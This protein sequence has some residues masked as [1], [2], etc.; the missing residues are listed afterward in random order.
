MAGLACGETIPDYVESGDSAGDRRL[1]ADTP[2]PGRAFSQARSGRAGQ[3]KA[4][5]AIFSRLLRGGRM[6]KWKGEAASYAP[7]LAY[8]IA[9][10]P[11]QRTAAVL[12][13]LLMGLAAN[14][15]GAADLYWDADGSGLQLGGTGTWNTAAPP[16]WNTTGNATAGPF[17][18]WNNGTPDNAIFAGT[19]GTVTLGA[20]ITAGSL[21]FN[22]SGYT[23]AGGTL[24]LGGGTPTITATGNATISSIIAGS[25]GLTKAGGGTLSLTGVNTFTGGITV[26]AGGFA[27]NADAALGAAANGIFAA[28][29]TSLTF[30]GSL[31]ASR[32]VTLGAGG[33]VTVTGAGAAA[34]R[35][36]GSGGIVA[37]T[38]TNAANDYTGPTTLRSSSSV[39]FSSI[40]NLGQASALGAPTTAANGTVLIMTGS[41]GDQYGDSASYTGGAASTDRGFE[42]RPGPIS[43]AT[44]TFR[45]SGSGMLTINGGIALTSAGSNS[46]SNSVSFSADSADLQLLGVISS[47][48][49]R[50]VNFTGTSNART[51]TLGDANT[52][53]GTAGIGAVT[54]KAGTM[55]NA[56]VNSSLGAGASISLGNGS[57][58]SYT[59]GAVGLDRTW[60]VSGAATLQSDGTGALTLNGAT[61]LA[62]GSTFT[63]GGSYTGSDNT[64]SGV[65]SGSGGL[66]SIGNATWVLTGANTRTGA[67]TVNGGTLRAG[68]AS[69]FGTIT[70]ITTNGGTLDLN[71]FNMSTT[72]LV[73]TGGAVA[74]GSGNLTLN[75]GTGVTNT[76]GGSITG[77][78]SLT[79]LGAGTLTLTG[80][81]TYTGATTIGGGTLALDFSPAG[82]PTS[83]IISASSPLVMNGGTLTVKGAAGETNLQSFGGLTIT[84]GNNTVSATSGAGGSTTVSLGAIT[85]TGGLAN[86]VLPTAGAIATSNADGALGG[87]ATV[88]GS[89]YA[90]VVGGNIVAFTAADYV[91][92]DNASLW[93]ANQILSDAG[94]AANTPFFNTVGASVQIGG[95]QYTAAANSTV[96]VASGQTLGIDGT[97]IVAP[98]VGAANQTITGGSMTGTLGGGVLG[99]QQNGT[100]TFTIASTIVDNTG[101]VGFSKAGTGKVV[102]SG[103]NTYTGATT[104]SQGTLSINSVANGGLASAIGASTSA[105]SNLMIQGATLEYTGTGASTDRGFTIARA[106]AITSSTIKVTNAAANL[107]FSG[108][109]VSPDGADFIKDGPGTLTLAGS[110]N[111]Y[112]GTTTVNSGTLAVTTLANGGTNSSIG[113]SSNA[114]SNLVLQNGGKLGYIGTIASSDRGFTLGTGGGGIDVAQATTTLTVSGVATGAG[115]LT[116]TGSGTLVLSGTNTYTGGTTVSAGI[117]RAGSAQAFGGDAAGTGAGAMTVAS[118]ATVDL[119]GN[120]VFV[121]GLNG[122]GNVTLGSGTLK[123]NSNGNFTG[124]IGGTGGVSITGGTQTF[125]GCGNTYAGA[126]TLSGNSV[127]NVGCLANGGELSDIGMSGSASTNLVFS[128]GALN[129]TGGTVSTNRGFTL[130][131][132]TGAIGVANAATTL[133]FS[134]QAT[135]LGTLR[136]DGPGTLMLSGTN[137]YSGGTTITGGILRAGSTSAFGTGAMTV[138]SGAT[139]DLAGNNNTVLGLNGG[140]SVTLGSGTL[141][142]SDGFNLTFSGAMSG[143]GGLVK[144]GTRTQTLSGCSSSY[145]GGTTINGGVLAVTCLNNGGI[146][147]SIGDSSAAATNLVLNGGTLQYIGAAGSTDRQFTL[148]AS[149]GTLDA[150]GTGAINFTSTTPVTL[151]GTG[152][153]TLTLAGSNTANNSLSARIDDPSGGVTSLTKSGA[154]T[155]VLN[156]TTSTYTGVTTISGGVLAVSK[157]AN[158]GQ[159]SS[160][161]Q[162]SNLASNLVIGSG[163]TLRY[164]GAG[165]ETDRLFTLQTGISFIESSGTGAIVFKNTGSAAYTGSGNRT[166]ALG[167]TNTGLNTMGGTI[168]DGPGGTTTLAKNDSGTWVLTGNNTFTGNTV[169][170]D[171]NLIIGNGG[172]SGNAGAGNVI[173]ANAT[174]TLSF[175]RSDSFSFT[176]TLSGAGNIA[177]IGTGTTILTSA[178]NAIG[179][180]TRIDAGTLQVNGSLTSSGG[181]TINAGTLQS[182]GG[183][184]SITTPTMTMNS[185]SKLNVGGG[186]VQ[187][188]GG[189]QTLFAGGTGGATINFTGGTLLGNGTLG[190]GGNIVNLAAGSLNTGAAALNLGSGNDTFLLSGL[191]TIAGVGVDGGGGSDTLQVT[192]TL[193]RTLNGAQITGFESLNKQGAAT[194]TLTGDHS[195]SAGT[196]ISA[197]TLQIGNGG[198]AGA[199]AT[200]NVT[201][202]GTLAFNLNNNYT[203]DSA[204][205]GSGVVNKLGTGTTTLTGTNTYIGATNVNAGTLL[206]NGNQSG[207]IGQTTV[208]SGATLGG[209]GTIG[210]SVTVADGGTLAPGGAGNAPGT[211]TIG[212]NLTLNN[213]SAVNVN[214]GQANVPGGPLND[215]INVGGNLTLDGTLNITQTSGGTFGPGVY[216]ILNYGGS[217]TNNGLNV[218]S[219]DYFVQ[220]AVA[221]QVNLV[222]S[223]GLTLSFW[224]GNAGPHSNDAVDGGSGTWRAAGDQNW[225]DATGTFAAP[226]ANAS[227]AIFQ[228]AAGTVTVDNTN[229]QVQA[230]GMQFATGGYL[231]QA[232]DVALVGLQS[233]IRVGDGTAAGAA[234]V[235]TITSNLT[236]SSQLLKTELGT[237]VLSGTNS[238]SG[239]TAINGGTVQ[240]ASDTNLGDASGGLSLNAGTLHTTA[241]ITSARAVTLNVGGGTFDTDSATKLTL[242]NTVS[243]AGTLTKE[244]GGTLVLSGANS[245]QSGT[246]INGGTVQITADANLGDAAG[247]VTFDGGTFYQ[248]GPASI[249]TGRTATLQAGGGTFQIDSTVQ[250]EGAIDGAGALTKTGTGALILGADNSYAGGTTISSGIL[251]LGT[252]GTTGSI[253]GDVV[254]NGT[255]SFN[256][257]DLYTFGGTIS[258]SGGVTQDGTGNTVLTADNTYGGTT[259]IVGGGGLYIDGDQSAA[260]GLANVNNGTLGGNGTIGGDVFVDVAG[261]LAPGGLGSTP[262]TL[263]INGNLE[264]A[265]SSNLD[266]SFGQAGVVGGA[267]NDLTVVHGNLAL[268]GTINVTEAPG[269]NFG[270]GIYRVISYDGALTDNGLD[271]TSSDHLVQTSVAGQV[272]LVDIS[273]MTLN[274]WDGDAGP[275]AN[276][277]VDG[278]NGTWRA[279]G[280]DNWTGSDGD[281]NAAFSNGSFAIFAGSAGTVTVDNTNGQV[282]AAGMQFATD[283]YLV[284][285]QDIELV[286]SQ[287][288]MR[289]GDGTLPGA[290]YTAT[291]NSNLTG[292]SQ[293]VKT[294]LGTLVLGGTN[295]Y[296]GGTAIHSG[297]LQV[298]ADANLGDAAGVLSFDNGATLRNTAAF[299]SARNVTLNA[300]GGTFQ[301]DAD[302]TLSGVVGGTGGFTKRGGA[303]LTLTG[304]SAY[305]GPTTVT[306]GGLYIDGDNSLATGITSVEFG[307]TLGGKGTI[308]GNVMVANGATLSP[309]S[310]DGTPGTLAIAGDLTLSGGSILNYSFGQA[311]VAGGAL[312]DLTTVGGNLVLDG[313][314]NV[315][316]SPGGTFGPG[317]YRVF[318][319]SGTLTNNGL[320]VGSIPSSNYFVQ[321]SVDHQVNLVNAN[322]L[323]LNYWD[324]DA[325]P[326]FDGTINGGNGTWQSS[327]GNDN[328]TED[329]GSINAAYSD[330][331]FAIFAGQAGTV[332]VDNGLGQVTAAG[333][334]FSTDGYV[335]Q[336]G[337][338]GLLGPQSTIRVGDGTNAGAG[339]TATIASAFTGSA[340][341]VK[342]DAGTLVLTGTNSYT[343]GTAING[344]TLRISADAN[345]GDAAGGLS[346][347][348]GTLNSTAS[349][350]SDRAIDVL[351]QGTISTD[352]GTTLT[353]NGALTGSGA[354]N[355]AGD[356]TLVLTSAGSTFS[357]STS[358]QQGTLAAG[359]ADVLSPLSAFTVDSSGTLD[360][361]SFDQTVAS[362]NNSG[363][364][365]LGAA[366]PGTVLTVSGDYVGNGG[367]ILIN[368]ALDGDGSTTDRLVVHGNTAG[369]GILAVT[370]VGGAGAQTS[371]GIKIVDIDGSSAG[372]FMLAGDYVFEGDQAVVGGAYAYRLY[373]NGVSTPADGDWYLRSTLIN[374]TGP[375]YAPSTPLYEAYEGV[376]RSFNEPGTLQQR[377]GNRAWGEGATPQG[378]DVPGQGPVDGNAIWA[379][380]DA[381]HGK[382]E[383]KTSTTGTDYDVTTW[384]LNAGVDG[385][386]H[387]SEAGILLGG[388]TVHYGTVSSDV[389]SSFGTGSISATGYGV[390]GT[391]TWLGNSGFY[392]DSQ[393]QAT[394]YDSDINSAVLGKLADGN[395]GFGYAL[396]IES[397]QK[398]ALRSNWS[399]T[400]QAQLSYS[401]VD[402]DK[403]TDPFGTIVS[404]GSGDSLIGRLGIS[405]D[406]EDQWADSAG[407]VSR[408]HVYGI[409]NLYYD[410]L[411][412]TDIDVSGVKLSSQNQKVWGGVG[413][414]GSLDFGDGKYSVY[415][416]ALAKTSLASFGDSNVVSGKLGFSVHW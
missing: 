287:A 26:S 174:S 325:G 335:I 144:N 307:A 67:I 104:V 386:L 143:A 185:G 202:N 198:V 58:L 213:T 187:A 344:G 73:G 334:Q 52:F 254:D 297:T 51:I 290:D 377:I 151:S 407:Q 78:G 131:G 43:G 327:S 148:G 31:N 373:K 243:G 13:A 360:L 139:L 165:D 189:T 38:L 103:S 352:A 170:N 267:Y 96:I 62:A 350:A 296:S 124:T 117:L 82:G 95:L 401:A 274:F 182:N 173:V 57:V 36:T 354:F 172:T 87:W 2:H 90:K 188:A 161:G 332:T 383:P 234:Y 114:S 91:N 356:G 365:R 44:L 238:Y 318:D 18:I 93:Q 175:N 99:V 409:A 341:L 275:K 28:A 294:D 353:L 1:K 130:Q 15:A 293:L 336:G 27:I 69:A 380:I 374:Q 379:R 71:G 277:G 105:S 282:Q 85:R 150:S 162:S 186:T 286:G 321:T 23:I 40:G 102:L 366:A 101:A 333:M 241:D 134:G 94:G 179:G 223:A 339:Y 183:G 25:G 72:S 229:G 50:F 212:G 158:G 309:G 167:G 80:A 402:F 328:W 141:T 190:G 152:N 208:A 221:N 142:L 355:K 203:F 239:G 193:S 291:I 393:A 382:F 219:P 171:G 236:G 322:G 200:P 399:L 70:G 284:Q 312:N 128:N 164:T 280:D 231:I 245:Y 249:V 269:G 358:V 385:L 181:I 53:G 272:N 403:F 388:I 237:L 226:F 257:S 34:A 256:R 154:G 30:N 412:G 392:V 372:T 222:N 405:A 126:T 283:G 310:A 6:T 11:R 338:I 330:S 252:G 258:G 266:Y 4:K 345:L 197:G 64:V 32:V 246:V 303:A 155:W 313:T 153:R 121:G 12:L 319:Y 118:G 196:T 168:I 404:P 127:L 3:P 163:S 14:P 17:V 416:E 408:A 115:S 107:T 68:S 268:D 214:F 157:L 314:L 265:D 235:A 110:N 138:N 351:G 389:S 65:I 176:G 320:S 362:L 276:D 194:L 278:G 108:Q 367:K 7:N 79:K 111:S 299:G 406:Y 230:A 264:L 347:N 35:Y 371:E 357:G 177:Q 140:G 20:P 116:K 396:S 242:T 37:A 74:M 125:S 201:N 209:T 363:A 211:L 295:S 259:L 205:S 317:I 135:G 88:N 109:V 250:W 100:G 397:G 301:T 316:V 180:S 285:G 364:V 414:G 54:V 204:L 391:L 292:V 304:A 16:L 122:A 75:L 289:V 323:N 262:G 160:I 98:S 178:T 119:A 159:A 324:G 137:D 133:T 281:I 47:S 255:L 24:T 42:L 123:I 166:L 89:D 381:A 220:T 398:I 326:K 191:A 232:G 375:L 315:T 415:G 343:G 55:A 233:T 9:S 305:A 76:Y 273:A 253:L 298:S 5:D 129:Y 370:N 60:S 346:F 340:Q 349:F 306:A 97:I 224:D 302:L 169:V 39:S 247:K 210:G 33:Q 248:Q 217:L 384:K 66:A 48:S 149:G 376:L 184:A 59:G 263:T 92:Q 342:T 400:P 8:T 369:A 61:T 394:W 337:D 86:F 22:V 207:A 106:G 145:D 136:K 308:G 218:T 311:N 113:A 279:A 395:K 244:G 361:A 251:M 387:E 46:G 199:L 132:G 192:T 228:G 21:T 261:R 348:G 29:G 206:I 83:G 156:N 300:G 271:T 49:G 84:T 411:D 288:T 227:F 240:V 112:T 147:S 41:G 390:G 329:T 146:A 19:A 10:A 215:L 195:Y 260:T 216:R 378:A 410:F 77:T 270:P 359:A 81:S 120:S 45:N 56:G 368:A 63:L 331:A 225:T 413:L